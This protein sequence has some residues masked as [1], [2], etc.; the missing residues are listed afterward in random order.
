MSTTGN[1]LT[2]P[3]LKEYCNERFG[4]CVTYPGGYFSERIYADNGDGL[5]LFAAERTIEVDITGA[6]NV[7]NWS[8]QDIVD[9]YFEIIQAK[10]MEVELLELHTEE[11]YG[12]AK[13]M[14]NNEIQLMQVNLLDDAYITTLIR[15]PASDEALI[16]KLQQSVQLTFAV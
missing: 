16:E 8:V 10:P 4:F 1:H 5:T 11:T 14:Y 2:T 7:M 3:D 13:M 9:D 15:V 6:Y 12:W